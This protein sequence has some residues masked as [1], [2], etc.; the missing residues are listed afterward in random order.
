[1]AEWLNHPNIK[2][3]QQFLGFTIFYLRF[4]HS[5]SS[6]LALLWGKP[7]K[8]CW[9][10]SGQVAFDFTI[11]LCPKNRTHPPTYHNHCTYMVGPHWRNP[12]HWT[13]PTS[14][15]P[16]MLQYIHTSLWH[17]VTPSPA[18][19]TLASKEPCS[20]CKIPSFIPW[21]HHHSRNRGPILWSLQAYHL[22][23]PAN[24]YGE[25]SYFILYSGYMASRRTG[26]LT[27]GSHSH[28][29][30][31]FCRKLGT[32][33]SLLSS[34]RSQSNMQVEKLNQKLGLY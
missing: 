27:E 30:K 15:V 7:K 10:E 25:W 4:V 11:I 13:S 3:L 9:S 8:L 14:W 6:V 26:S 12:P 17:W 2:E 34:Y 22:E 5:Y 1:M 33:V 20:S 21:L 32:N 24:C 29:W 16:P 18:L 23:N 31:A 19:S 28:V